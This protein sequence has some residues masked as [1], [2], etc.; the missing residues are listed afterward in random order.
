MHAL[1]NMTIVI[2]SFSVDGNV[3]FLYAALQTWDG[4]ANP[5]T[6]SSL[7]ILR[8]K[9]GKGQ[10]GEVDENHVCEVCPRQTL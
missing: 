10:L 2:S 9:K 7:S 4:P 1:D 6:Q 8:A 3:L 5:Q